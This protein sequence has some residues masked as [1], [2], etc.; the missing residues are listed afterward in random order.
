[1][2]EQKTIADLT[3]WDLDHMALYRSPGA[4]GDVA[5]YVKG[6]LEEFVHSRTETHLVIGTT[7]IAI[8][9]DRRAHETILLDFP[10]GGSL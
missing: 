6:A 9:A 1:M 7:T 4:D 5:I 2:P 8:D 10:L 3:A